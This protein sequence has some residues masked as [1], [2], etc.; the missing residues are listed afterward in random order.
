MTTEQKLFNA[1]DFKSISHD[2][3]MMYV[4]RGRALQAQE[5]RHILRTLFGL[6][7]DKSVQAAP[8]GAIG[9]S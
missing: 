9:A 1:D 8:K 7:K 4:R 2:D 5:T 6:D 3:I